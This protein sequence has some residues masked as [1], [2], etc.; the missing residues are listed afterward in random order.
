MDYEALQSA[1]VRD[2]A[3]AL[4]S[5]PLMRPEA[6]S[7]HWFDA[8]WYRRLGQQSADW[9]HTLDANPSALQ[10]LLQAQ[11]DQRLG[12]YFE[13]LWMF[14]FAHS[15]HYRLLQRNLQVVAAGRTL[16]ELDCIVEERASGRRLHIELAVKFYLGVADTGALHNWHGANSNDRLDH[17]MQALLRHQSVLSRQPEVAGILR[18]RGIEV[19]DCA[20]ILKGRLFYPPQGG[21]APRDSHPGHLRGCWL[22]YRGFDCM[23]GH[24]YAPL[25][26]GDWLAPRHGTQGPVF[27]HRAQLQSMLDSGAYRLPLL[28]RV[29]NEAGEQQRLFLV[30]DDWPC[31]HDR[32]PA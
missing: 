10:S 1:C 19:D 7:C 25:R 4:A 26:R 2:L 32:P 24:R 20:V 11:R 23:P 12:A 30:P 29:L 28:L 21:Q 6:T 27:T 9:L 5:P 14:Y 22:H 18:D 13:S 16:G 8:D 31:R 3:W 17:K 15:P